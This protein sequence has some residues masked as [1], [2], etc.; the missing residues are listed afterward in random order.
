MTTLGFAPGPNQ[1][2]RED[3]KRRIVVSANVRWRDIGSFVPEAESMILKGVNIP[4]GY[5]TRWGRTF[6][7]LQSAP[8]RLRLVVPLAL[9]LAAR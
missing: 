5:W 7:Q 1:I 6:E 2:S 3:S 9:F 8:W 4:P